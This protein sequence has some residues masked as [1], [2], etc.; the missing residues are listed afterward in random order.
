[1]TK[2][3]EVVAAFQ[4][5]R[6]I[7]RSGKSEFINFSGRH[8]GTAWSELVEAIEGLAE[9]A[10]GC[11]EGDE[12]VRFMERYEEDAIAQASDSGR[13]YVHAITTISDLLDSLHATLAA[14]EMAAADAAEWRQLARR[15]YDEMPHN[16]PLCPTKAGIEKSE[17]RSRIVASAIKLCREK[18]QTDDKSDSRQTVAP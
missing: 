13:L 10:V 15:Q 4:H 7:Q 11:L 8:G 2:A 6:A 1:M 17:E 12:A 14:L 9:D 16:A 3:N 5:Y 18:I